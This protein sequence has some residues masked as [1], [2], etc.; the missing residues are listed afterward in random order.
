MEL[1]ALG[2][3]F[4]LAKFTNQVDKKH[5]LYNGHW[6][7]VGHYLIVRTWNPNFN[8]YEAKINK[9]AL[10]VRLPD[11]LMEY[12][13]NSVL[14]IIRNKI[15]KTLKVDIAISISIRGNYVRIYMEVD[16]TKPLLAKFK[17][18]RR[19][20]RIMYEGLHLIC[21][22][23]GQYGHKQKTCPYSKMKV[24]DRRYANILLG[25]NTKQCPRIES[26][27]LEVDPVTRLEIIK[28]YGDQMIAQRKRRHQN[29][30]GVVMEATKKYDEGR[31]YP[32]S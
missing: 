7:I 29:K 24:H 14:W 4:F 12:Y 19:V 1:V 32:V 28:N 17:L 23:C 27:I 10:Q 13:D 20:R 3:D 30:K 2:N 31:R 6:M 9:V 15:G 8:P 26:P 11:L 21:F 16:L 25:R 5:A 18:Q 22:H